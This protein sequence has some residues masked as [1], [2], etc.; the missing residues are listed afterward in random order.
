MTTVPSLGND[1]LVGGDEGWIISASAKLADDGSFGSDL[2]Q[3]FYGSESHYYFNLPL[4]HLVLAAWFKVAGV[5]MASARLVSVIYGLA[6]LLLT[7][8]LGRSIGGRWVGLGAA[9]LLVLLRLNLTPFTGLTLTDLGAT[10]RY[11]LVTVPYGLGAAL[12]LLRRR[13]RRANEPPLAAVIG[14]GVLLGLAAL[15]QFV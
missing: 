13:E 2:F 11:D 6:A 12:L 9:A 14:A 3:G 8:A 5:S 4:H 7:Y 15:T 1:P 10:V